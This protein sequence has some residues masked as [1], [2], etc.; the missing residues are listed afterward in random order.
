MGLPQ[1]FLVETVDVVVAAG[2]ALRLSFGSRGRVLR[3]RGGVVLTEDSQR[4]RRE[5][6]LILQLD[7]NPSSNASL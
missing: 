1:G 2:S 5:T 6:T 7:R 4:R 3:V